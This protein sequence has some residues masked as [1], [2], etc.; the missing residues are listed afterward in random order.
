MF[1]FSLFFKKRKWCIKRITACTVTDDRITS[2]LF[3]HSD[4]LLCYHYFMVTRF[5]KGLQK[6][7]LTMKAESIH[8]ICPH[9]TAMARVLLGLGGVPCYENRISQWNVQKQSETHPKNNLFFPNRG[10][11]TTIRKDEMEY[12]LA[13][14]LDWHCPCNEHAIKWWLLEI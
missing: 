13:L 10:Q 6:Y 11:L 4:F 9:C 8:S 3:I 7:Q 2:S 5:W 14:K 12:F 1:F